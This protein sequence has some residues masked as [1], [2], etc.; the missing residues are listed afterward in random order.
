[1]KTQI[2]KLKEGKYH[3][4]DNC[5]PKFILET[6][7]PISEALTKIYNKS[8]EEGK[9]PEIWRTANVIALQQKRYQKTRRK[10]TGL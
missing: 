4:P 8:L 3:G 7:E 10:I 5:H 2:K 1:M 6:V 9:I